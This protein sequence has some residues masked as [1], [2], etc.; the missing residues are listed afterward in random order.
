[1]KKLILILAV[2]VSSNVVV[3][4]DLQKMRAKFNSTI[5]RVTSTVGKFEEERAAEEAKKAAATSYDSDASS[6]TVGDSDEEEEPAFFDALDF[7]GKLLPDDF[8][9]FIAQK[10]AEEVV[11]A[12]ANLM[13]AEDFSVLGAPVSEVAE[14][15]MAPKPEID[16]SSAGSVKDIASMFEKTH[17][18]IKF[19]DATK[20]L[21]LS[22]FNGYVD[23]AD[24][25]N[26]DNSALAEQAKKA[27]LVK[28]NSN[29]VNNVSVLVYLL[30]KLASKSFAE[31]VALDLDSKVET[32][33]GALS[34]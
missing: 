19:E 32:L 1:M 4:D 9:G 34:S 25:I 3:A 13:A 7:D 6:V 20:S 11:S 18:Q 16:L 17:A 30:N 10:P 22:D 24:R 5:D 15:V 33:K 31:I 2:F 21:N 29:N 14:E 28:L 26:S 23:A 12:E 8:S 27:I